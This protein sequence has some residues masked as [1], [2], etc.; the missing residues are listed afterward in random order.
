MVPPS[1]PSGPGRR[2]DIRWGAGDRRL[3]GRVSHMTSFLGL[4][5]FN[6]DRSYTYARPGP[7]PRVPLPVTGEPPERCGVALALSL[8]L[9]QRVCASVELVRSVVRRARL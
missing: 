2:Q 8:G 7:R 5:Y 1:H 3:F 4:R 9:A 6:Q